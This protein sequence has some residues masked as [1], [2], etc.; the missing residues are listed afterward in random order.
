MAKTWRVRLQPLRGNKHA[1]GFI[2]NPAD[3]DI[4]RDCFRAFKAD[5]RHEFYDVTISVPTR[6]RTLDQNKLYR[7]LLAIAAN[8]QGDDP[9]QLHEAMIEEYA[10]LL[11]T[12]GGEVVT[13]PTD[14]GAPRL[15]R[16]RSSDMTTGEMAQF[17]QKVFGH[18]AE[19]GV[20]DLENAQAIRNYWIE[21]RNWRG[22]GKADPVTFE[23]V[24]EYRR[25][26]T[27][28]EACVLKKSEHFA[29]IGGGG[30]ALKGPSVP[31]NGLMLC[32]RCHLYTQHQHGWNR[33]CTE[34][35]HVRGKVDAAR[36]RLG[37]KPTG[38]A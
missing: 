1:V 26:Q 36:K 23:S 37:L 2:P 4:I 14:F 6:R 16:K 31:E 19:L 32:T 35:P 30:V 5:E 28:C 11:H 8:E 34:Y 10:P 33:L 29:H 18:V 12:K 9:E 27:W 24:A 38:K 15:V 20:H 21:W 7:G 3:M 17:I 13:V 22:K 25:M